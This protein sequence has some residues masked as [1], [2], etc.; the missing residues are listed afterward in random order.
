MNL[1]NNN[2]N[3]LTGGSGAPAGDVALGARTLVDI[4]AE[5]TLRFGDRIA[6]DA[7]GRTLTYGELAQR[8][9]D[10][11]ARLWATGIG[12]GDRVGVHISSGTADLYVGILG[13]LSSGAAYVPVD[14]DDPPAR[15]EAIWAG[16]D[17]CAIVGDGLRITQRHAPVGDSRP[18]RPD[19]D[20]WVIFTSGS[21]AVPKAVAVTHA[22]AA[23]FVD[24]E[25]QLWTVHETD[26]V[27]AGLS[28]GFD[29]SCEEM[30][31]AWRSGAALVPAPRSVVRSAAD[32]GPWLAS[33]HITV[34]STVP[35]LASMWDD[36]VVDGVRLLILGGEALPTDLAW[37]LSERVEVWN[38]YG[39]TEATV[40]TTAARMSPG[41][42]VLIGQPLEGWEVAVLDEHDQPVAAG[43]PGELM[44]AGVGLGRYLDPELDR[45]R[46]APHRACGW[47]R[48]YRTGDIVREW[49]DGYAFV[50]RRDDRGCPVRRRT[51]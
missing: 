49:P 47:E 16:A 13:V 15:A 39:P 41:V 32:L 44:I 9:E 35:T 26:R 27:L 6:L 1:S 12:A 2:S 17:V 51:S 38:T 8:V 30:W 34:V 19:D 31:L 5:T 33:H 3:M 22:S 43:E 42:P 50:G 10:L 4:L 29:A 11:A 46:Y 21:T 28:V 25:T 14:V 37:R 7:E 23:A 18:L 45:Q 48:T 36:H 24:A 20:A 40:V